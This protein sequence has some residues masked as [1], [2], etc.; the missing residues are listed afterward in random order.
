MRRGHPDQLSLIPAEPPPVRLFSYVVRYDSGF[1]P[2]PFFD[3][4]TLAT[5]K[6]DIRKAAQLGHWVVGTGSADKKVLRGGHLVYAM[7]VTDVLTFQDYDA[8]TRFPRKKPDLGISERRACGDNVYYQEDGAWRQRRSFHT[9]LDGSP[10]PK[11]IARDTGVNRVLVSDDYVYLG[12][13]GPPIPSRFRGD[14]G[15]DI[16]KKGQG[17]KI[18]DDPDLIGD[19]VEWLRSLGEPGYVSAPLD[20]K[21]KRGW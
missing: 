15:F 9:E 8:D 21:L 16:C 11:H 17:R 7:K 3:F 2:N 13:Y 14:H 10:N 12:G 19:F 5:C 4:C 20:W 18:F 1:A 6:P